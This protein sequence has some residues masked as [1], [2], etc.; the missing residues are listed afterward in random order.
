M[1]RWTLF[2]LLGVLSLGACGG[3]KKEPPPGVEALEILT[4]SPLPDAVVERDYSVFISVRGGTLPY[5]WRG[6]AGQLPAG[7]ELTPNT[8]FLNGTASEAGE[9]TFTVEVRDA[10]DPVQTATQEYT[11]RVAEPLV[12]TTEELP[13]ATVVVDYSTQLEAG[14]GTGEVTWSLRFG[15]LPDGLG[16]DATGL[17]SGVPFSEGTRRFGVLVEDSGEPPQQAFKSLSITVL[18]GTP[19]VIARASVDSSGTE[20]NGASSAPAVSTSG[21]QVA[22]ESLATNLV[23]TD[24]NNASDI[25]LFDLITAT[26]TRLSLTTSGGQANGASRNV[27][28][29]SDL[30]AAAFASDA[31]NLAGADT[32]GVADIYLRLINAETSGRA[33]LRS[34]ESEANGASRTPALSDDGAFVAFASDAS[35]LVSGDTNGLRDI[36]LRNRSAGTTT[37]ISVGPGGAQAT[38]ASDAPAISGT[39]DAVAFESSATELTVPRTGTAHIFLHEPDLAGGGAGVTTVVSVALN[40]P[41]QTA[42]IFGPDSIGNTTLTMTPNEHAGRR[43][44]IV[45]GKK[46]EL[47]NQIADIFSA[48]TIGNSTLMMVT[49]EHV[50]RRVEIVVGAGVGQVRRVV[51]N[52]ATTLTVDAAWTTLPGSTSVFRVVSESAGQERL[53]SSNTV[54]TLFVATPWDTTPDDTS[55]FRVVS[56]GD[57]ASAAAAISADGRFVAFESLA[58]NLIGAGYDSNGARDIFVHDRATGATFRVSVVLAVT[59]HP[60]DIFSTNTIGN[61]SLALGVDAHVGQLVEIV[62]GRGAGQ[63]RRVVVNDLT[64]LAVDVSWTTTPDGTSSFRVVSESNGA[65]FTPALSGDG[66]FVAFQSLASNLDPSDTNGLA[67]IFVFDRETGVTTHV[68]VRP[69]RDPDPGAEGDGASAAPAI[70]RDGRFCAFVSDATNLLTTPDSNGVAD[71]F[72]AFTGVP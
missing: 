70:S 27:A 62:A 33:S 11:L 3:K 56:E 40:L 17:I 22:F 15:R 12:V 6:S 53:I 57:A 51:A 38:G 69:P 28:L 18:P 41:D 64:T 59:T 13:D 10:T 52:D 36:F 43:V 2:L 24:T 26:T 55:V 8:G 7:F 32:N 1:R 58:T 71:I 35:D 34:D 42:D 9:F 72:L 50:G 47:A 60:A 29:T 49:D 30:T 37:R 54:D 67:D 48:T 68:S 61:S 23:A 66:R 63:V 20:A 16:L 65:S 46:V 25:F 5:S 19:G 45:S 31:T 14:G 44:R 21:R 4:T 39:G